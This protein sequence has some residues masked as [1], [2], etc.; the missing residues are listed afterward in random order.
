MFYNDARFY[1]LTIMWVITMY[2]FIA[3]ARRP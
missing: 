1:I 3:K 2:F